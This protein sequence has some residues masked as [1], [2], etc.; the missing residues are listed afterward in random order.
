[1]VDPLLLLSSKEVYSGK[2]W[3]VTLDEAALPDGRRKKAERVHRPDS[4]HILAFPTKG[5]VVMIREFRPFYGRYIWMIPSGKVDKE[6]DPDI[7]AQRELREET[8]YR[9]D[10]LHYYCMVRH[11]DQ[12]TSKNWI[13][14]A[15]QL[16]RDPLELDPT[17]LIEVHEMPIKDAIDKV[18]ND[19]FAHSTTAYALLRYAREHGM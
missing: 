16:V 18:L 13:Y 6:N 3:Q 19:D 15:R 7:A 11:M 8:S 10:D 1:M 2:N 14:I 12:L 4:V 9:S 5:S 17:E